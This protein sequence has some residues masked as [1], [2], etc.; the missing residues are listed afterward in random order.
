[1]AAFASQ[2][3]LYRACACLYKF[4]TPLCK[5]NGSVDFQA[6]FV[7]SSGSDEAK[8]LIMNLN[9][10]RKQM[11]VELASGSNSSSMRLSC[12]DIYLPLI[13]N[14]LNSLNM[15]PPVAIEKQFSFEWRG[16]FCAPEQMAYNQSNEMIFELGMVLHTKAVLHYN[17]AAEMLEGDVATNLQAAGQNLRIAAGIMRYLGTDLLPKWLAGAQGKGSRPPELCE[18]V[19][20]AYAE[21]FTASAQQ[22]AFVKALVKVG[23]SPAGI[24]TKVG[25]GV[26]TLI[27]GNY[28]PARLLPDVKSHYSIMRELYKA[29]VSKYQ[30]VTYS[31]KDEKGTAI[32]YCQEAAVSSCS[33]SCCP[34]V[35]LHRFTLRFLLYARIIDKYCVVFDCLLL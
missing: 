4:R 18:E 22:M 14:L 5:N 26:V 28:D 6:S 10:S 29:L 27:T 11:L 13:T 31:D 1:M 15:Q 9:I 7:S 33:C 3:S 12:L 21:L 23:G 20:L 32:G 16:A 34:A 2:D 24:L 25:L 19:C 8:A 35:F 30:A 17:M